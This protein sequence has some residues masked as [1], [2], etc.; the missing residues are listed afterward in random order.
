MKKYQKVQNNKQAITRYI[1][2]EDQ[3]QQIKGRQNSKDSGT[4]NHENHQQLYKHSNK[5]DQLPKIYKNPHGN[6][7]EKQR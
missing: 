5:G 6:S 7:T 2:E 1:S 3:N 4:D